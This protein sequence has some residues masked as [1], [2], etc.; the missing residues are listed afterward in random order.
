MA[1]TQSVTIVSGVDGRQYNE[2]PADGTVEVGDLIRP[3][4]GTV[5]SVEKVPTGGDPKG[6][7]IA[8]EFGSVEYDGSYDGT[9]MVKYVE[10]QP[11]D[12]FYA[13]VAG[14]DAVTPGQTLT[15]PQSTKG[16]AG[17][18]SN[19]GGTPV[20]MSQGSVA[21]TTKDKIKVTVV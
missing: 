19:G 21:A 9:E 13:N 3:K 4:P 6:V 18:M 20:A 11:G 15:N 16:T 2:A 10:A 8:V 5:G 7:N 12:E 1:G 17:Y 14:S